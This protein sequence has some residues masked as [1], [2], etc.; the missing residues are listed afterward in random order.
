MAWRILL[1]AVMR[2]VHIPILGTMIFATPR[3]ALTPGDTIAGS[4]QK[5]SSEATSER[6]SSGKFDGIVIVVHG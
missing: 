6:L 3:S 5:Q 1:H 4:P 2:S